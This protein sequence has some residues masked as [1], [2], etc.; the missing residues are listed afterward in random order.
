MKP[1]IKI[2]IG[3]MCGFAGGFAA[4]FF[5]HKKMT[6]IQFEEISEE[7]MKEIEEKIQNNKKEP[8][9]EVKESK[10]ETKILK[11]GDLPTD[12]DKL[13]LKLQGKTPYIQAD[14]EQKTAYEKMWKITKSYSDEENA[15]DIPVE[16]ES[17]GPE[18]EDFDEDFLEMIEEETVEPGSSF[19]EPPH[20][21]DLPA[22][23]ND[24][25]DFDKIT[26]NWWEEDNVWTD[27]KDEIIPDIS[28]Y[29]GEVDI[30]GS[31]KKTEPGDDPDVRFVRNDQYGTDYEI[32][33]HHRSWKEETQGVE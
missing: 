28:S 1:W 16:G 21:I 9:E 30:V 29:V 4:G 15:N 7:E 24:R 2:F 8:T 14:A 25:P 26:I 33:R 32:I 10:P 23:Y 18:E 31:F 17:V 3:V 19:V 13:K 27:E 5:S 6:D 20:I 12:P 22:F 11:D